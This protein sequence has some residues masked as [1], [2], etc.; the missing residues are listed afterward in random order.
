MGKQPNNTGRSLIWGPSGSVSVSWKRTEAVPVLGDEVEHE[1]TM[2]QITR[3]WL[4]REPKHVRLPNGEL[5]VTRE[6]EVQKL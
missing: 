1:G 5:R 6:V 3:T 2:F 4:M